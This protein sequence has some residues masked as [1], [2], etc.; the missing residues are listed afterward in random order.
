MHLVV[1]MLVVVLC[2]CAVCGLLCCLVWLLRC[3]NCDG[4][5]MFSGALN[6]GVYFSWLCLICF[7]LSVW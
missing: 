7:V 3:V 6:V 5:V 2:D 4:Q 1:L